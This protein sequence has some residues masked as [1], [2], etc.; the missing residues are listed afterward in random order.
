MLDVP[1]HIQHPD[2]WQS[3]ARIALEHEVELPRQGQLVVGGRPDGVT[4]TLPSELAQTLRRSLLR[5][6]LC[7]DLLDPNWTRIFHFSFR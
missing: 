6:I 5:Q 4:V 7:D 1:C 2:A 3:D